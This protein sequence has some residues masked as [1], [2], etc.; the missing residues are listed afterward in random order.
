VSAVVRQPGEPPT[1]RWGSSSTVSLAPYLAAAEPLETLRN[2]VGS[3]HGWRLGPA[4]DPDALEL[5]P[6]IGPD[7]F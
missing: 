1:A 4:L 7:G 6:A 5:L 2:L 3:M